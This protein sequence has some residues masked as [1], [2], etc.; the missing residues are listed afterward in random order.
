VPITENT[1]SDER[2]QWHIGKCPVEF[3]PKSRAG[4]R[5]ASLAL[6]GEAVPIVDLPALVVSTQH[7]ERF[8]VLDLVAHQQADG[9]YT[10]RATVDVVCKSNVQSISI[11][12][13]LF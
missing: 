1:A 10:L 13:T 6:F 11:K 2:R 8:W 3:F 5:I 9:L 7:E 4:V 12:C